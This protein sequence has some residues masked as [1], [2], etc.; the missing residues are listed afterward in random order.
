MYQGLKMC[1]ILSPYCCCCSHGGWT[2][3][4]H[5]GHVFSVLMCCFFCGVMVVMV[6]GGWWMVDSEGA[7]NKTVSNEIKKWRKTYLGLETW[8]ISSPLLLGWTCCSS[9][10]HVTVEVGDDGGH[11]K[12]GVGGC[13]E[14]V[15]VVVVVV[16]TVIGLVSVYARILQFQPIIFAY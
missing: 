2:H 16:V 4:C 1:C 3:C 14:G 8:H 7:C 9:G 13:V 12:G 11:V 15:M 10:W 5:G 6:D